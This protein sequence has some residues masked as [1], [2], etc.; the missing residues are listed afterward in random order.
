[1]WIKAGAD[2]DAVMPISAIDG[3]NEQHWADVRQIISDAID[4]SGFAPQLVSD[5]D[6]VGVIQRR[7]IRSWS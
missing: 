5:A 2:A 6:E 3:C 1:M 4:D 7:I